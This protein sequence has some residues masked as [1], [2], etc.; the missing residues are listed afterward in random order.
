MWLLTHGECVR[1][2]DWRRFRGS[3]PV[4][5]VPGWVRSTLVTCLV[6]VVFGHIAEVLDDIS[7]S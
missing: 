7:S 3:A 5:W 4:M 1:L 2:R 6:E